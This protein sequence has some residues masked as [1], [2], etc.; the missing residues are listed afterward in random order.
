MGAP[1]ALAATVAAALHGPAGADDAVALAAAVATVAT[2]WWA[3]TAD[4]FVDGSSYGDERRFALRSPPSIL[5]A[6]A[7]VAWVLAV[8]VPAA[9]ALLLAAGAWAAGAVAAAVGAAGIR[10][11]VPALHRLSRRWLVLVPAGLVVHDHI[12]LADPV[13]LRRATLRGLSAAPADAVEDGAI[14]LTCGAGG[15]P[16]QLVLAQVVELPVAVG[17]GRRRT[18]TSTPAAAVLVAPGRPGAF[19]RVAGERLAGRRPADLPGPAA[20]P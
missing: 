2:A 19:L 10:L 4:A 13:L 7:P 17:Q 11:G 14:D 15:L 9:A 18:V 8:V 1:A 6:A 16:V 12:A 20:A 3:V 5:V